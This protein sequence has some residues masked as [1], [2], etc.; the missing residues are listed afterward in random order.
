MDKI[1]ISFILPTFNER[2]NI[3]ILIKKLLELSNNYELEIIIVDDNSQDGTSQVVR[4]FAKSEKNIR[5]IHRID[6]FGLSSAIKEGCLNSSYETIAI[7]DADGQHKLKDTLSAVD[8]LLSE[9]LDVV[10]GSRFLD[11]SL[12]KGLSDK[13]ERLSIFANNIARFSL[14][15]KY[16]KLTDYMSGCIALNR[17]TCMRYLRKID[18]NGFKFFYELL[19][20]SKGNLKFGEIPLSFQPRTSGIS[21]FDAAIVWDFFISVLHAF[22]NRLIPRQAISFALVGTIGVIVQLLS[23]Y[24]LVKLIGLRFENALIIAVVIAASSNFFINNW[25]TFAI[26]RLK[27]INLLW[28]LLRFLMVSSLPIIANIGLATAFYQNISPNTLLSQLAAIIIVFIW[29]YTASSRFVW[30]I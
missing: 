30:K 26:R 20:I 16:S 11:Y 14:P 10:C 19:S 22:V 9:D 18:L 21:K 17:N 4:G 28:G 2:E 1:K 8:K 15:N 7:M 5:L 3:R 27:N 23:S 13:R 12:V 6:R 24:I 25:F 29:N